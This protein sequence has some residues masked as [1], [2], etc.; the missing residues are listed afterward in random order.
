MNVNSTGDS[1]APQQQ[2]DEGNQVEKQAEVFQGA[3]HV[4]F[5]PYFPWSLVTVD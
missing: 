5:L 4:L 1:D 2:G 3:T